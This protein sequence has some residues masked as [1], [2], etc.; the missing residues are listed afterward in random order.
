MKK[1]KKR[2]TWLL[3]TLIFCCLTGIGNFKLLPVHAEDFLTEGY[4]GYSIVDEEIMIH[5]YFGKEVDVLIPEKIAG[6]PVTK[7]GKETFL[8][9]DQ[10]QTITIPDT[11]TY[12]EEDTLTELPN[13][14]KIILKSD[15]VAVKAAEHVIILEDYPR[16]IDPALLK[17]YVEEQ[18]LQKQENQS[19]EKE[20]S[21]KGKEDSSKGKEDSS[22]GKEDSS[23]GKE[24]SFKEKEDSNREEAEEQ[25]FSV[26]MD[27]SEEDTEEKTKATEKAEAA[28]KMDTSKQYAGVYVE[29]NK[30]YITVDQ[31]HH[32]IAVDEQGNV[33]RIEK[34]KEYYLGHRGDGMLRIFD[35]EGKELNLSNGQIQLADGKKIILPDKDSIK[36]EQEKTEQE[37]TEQE[38]TEQKN[39][40][41]K[42]TVGAEQRDANEEQKEG[43]SGLFFGLLMAALGIL[44]LFAAGKRI[45][46]RKK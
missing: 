5:S 12:I 2:S 34:E 44:I 46:M 33:K 11:V 28:E 42:K 18:E 9:R 14:W 7:I 26:E 38:K 40:E 13:L 24:D 15:Q 22:K 1:K 21:T 37:K 32:L 17:K 23:K 3:F 25:N 31:D 6:Y 36:T 20:D 35:R 19:K 10:I 4:F 29:Q 43:E 41:R 8:H 39:A 45:Y 16:Y 30:I 27:S